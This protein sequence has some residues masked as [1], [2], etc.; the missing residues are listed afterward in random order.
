MG[1]GRSVG[2]KMR[3]YECR[4]TFTL[5]KNDTMSSNNRGKLFLNLFAN[6]HGACLLVEAVRQLIAQHGKRSTIASL[7]R[8]V[9]THKPGARSCFVH[10]RPLPS[11]GDVAQVVSEFNA[12]WTGGAADSPASRCIKQDPAQN[13]GAV[14]PRESITEGC[15]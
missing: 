10:P 5:L 12:T 7:R 4:R 2:K 11:C 6:R 9:R 8:H 15:A 1:S 14:D 13:T 3:N